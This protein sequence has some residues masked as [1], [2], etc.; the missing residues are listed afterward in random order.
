MTYHCRL[1]D[2]SM[3]YMSETRHIKSQPH[4]MFSNSIV[5]RYIIQN[6]NTLEKGNTRR[7]YNFNHNNIFD[8]YEVDIGLRVG[9]NTNQNKN[10]KLHRWNVFHKL[11]RDDLTIFSDYI[12]LHQENTLLKLKKKHFYVQK[13]LHLIIVWLIQCMP[14]NVDFI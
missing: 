5:W 14:L 1:C 12:K 9:T 11:W 2:K 4:L 6:P 13:I 10:I 3:K 8:S 7:K